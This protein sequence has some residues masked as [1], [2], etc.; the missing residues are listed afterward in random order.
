VIGSDYYLPEPCVLHPETVTEYPAP[1]ELPRDLAE[2]IR[3]WEQ[4]HHLVYQFDLGVAPGC[5]VGGYGPWSFSDPFPMH[6]HACG[7]SVRP[8]LTIDGCEWDG[9]NRSWRPLEDA[10]LEDGPSYLKPNTPTRL[11]IGRGYSLQLYTCTVS[12][13]HPHLHNMQ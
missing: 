7:A 9:G 12:Y 10:G 8:L 11:D 3:S 6:C 13:A 1:H 2:R 5:K 4:D